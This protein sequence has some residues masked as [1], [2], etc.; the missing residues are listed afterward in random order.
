MRGMA[1]AA[2]A[3]AAAVSL[4]PPP[5]LP[6]PPGICVQQLP[7]LLRPVA[8]RANDPSAGA[9]EAAQA[10]GRQAAG[11]RQLAGAGSS[12]PR[13]E[14][15]ATPLAAVLAQ[16][17]EQASPKALPPKAPRRGPIKRRRTA[18]MPEDAI[19]K[20][21]PQLWQWLQKI[22]VAWSTK[23]LAWWTE[24]ALE[25]CTPLLG[26][27]A[28]GSAFAAPWILALLDLLLG[29]P[30]LHARAWQDWVQAS[31]ALEARGMTWPN[32]ELLCA[33]TAL[34]VSCTTFFYRCFF[35][36][37]GHWQRFFDF[38]YVG[39]SVAGTVRSSLRSERPSVVPALQDLPVVPVLALACAVATLGPRPSVVSLPYA[40]LFLALLGSFVLHCG[41]PRLRKPWRFAL[42]ALTSSHL[43]AL[44]MLSILQGDAAQICIDIF[45]L[46]GKEVSTPPAPWATPP[47]AADGT[48]TAIHI[49]ALLALHFVL[50]NV[51]TPKD[52]E[53]GPQ[54]EVDRETQ[55]SGQELPRE[56]EQQELHEDTGAGLEALSSP[57]SDSASPTAAA[58]KD[59]A[60][61]AD[62]PDVNEVHRSRQW[63]ALALSGL[64]SLALF[65]F[66][67]R[68]P[69]LLSLPL[70]LHVFS[71]SFL[72]QLLPGVCQGLLR[73][74]CNRRSQQDA[75]GGTE[76]CGRR[77]SRYFFV[78]VTAIF[79]LNY[80]FNIYL[81]GPWASDWPTRNA[82]KL[83]RVG[84]DDYQSGGDGGSNAA[85]W[86]FFGQAVLLAIL[87]ILHVVLA[88]TI[89]GPVPLGGLPRTDAVARAM[90]RMCAMVRAANQPELSMVAV[91]VFIIAALSCEAGNSS[92][93]VITYVAVLALLVTR[94]PDSCAEL[95][96][97]LWLA[98]Q[99]LSQAASVLMMLLYI[100]D[101]LTDG[102]T[103][104][105]SLDHVFTMRSCGT[106]HGLITPHIGIFLCAW[107]Q[108]YCYCQEA[109]FLASNAS[110]APGRFERDLLGILGLQPSRERVAFTRRLIR[111]LDEAMFLVVM[112]MSVITALMPRTDIQSLF[113]L[114]IVGP[115]LL[116]YNFERVPL[117]C[118]LQHSHEQ[119]QL[120]ALTVLQYLAAFC[121]LVRIT[122]ASPL[123]PL[124]DD[125]GWVLKV[126]EVGISRPL[127]DTTAKS[128]LLG[129]TAIL[130][131]L[132]A[133]RMDAVVAAVPFR[134]PDAEPSAAREAPES[135]GQGGPPAAEPPEAPRCQAA[136]D[137]ARLRTEEAA[138]AK[139]PAAGLRS[140]S[141]DSEQT[142]TVSCAQAG[143]SARTASWE[144]RL[145]D[146]WAPSWLPVR[147]H[148]YWSAMLLIVCFALSSTEMNVLNVLMIFAVVMLCGSSKHWVQAGD[149]F[150]VATVGIMLL[151]YIFRFQVWR[152][153]MKQAW[154]EHVG[155]R[156]SR[157]EVVKHYV[158]LILCLIQKQLSYR[159]RNCND[160]R[161]P[162][163]PPWL[164]KHA[165]ILGIILLLAVAVARRH[166][167]SVL[168]ALA[169]LPWLSGR[170]HLCTKK[171]DNSSAPIPGKTTTKWLRFFRCVLVLMLLFQISVRLGMAFKVGDDFNPFFVCVCGLWS[172]QAESDCIDEWHEWTQI[173]TT[174][175]GQL[176]W[177]FL[178]LFVLGYIQQ[179][180]ANPEKRT[181]PTPSLR[182][183]LVAMHWWPCLVWTSCFLLSLEGGNCIGICFLCML[184][185][186]TLNAEN[187]LA[188]RRK[189]AWRTRFCAWGFLIFGIAAQSPLFPCSRASCTGNVHRVWMKYGD[190]VRVESYNMSLVAREYE[191]ARCLSGGEALGHD[192]WA[193]LALQTLGITRVSAEAEGFTSGLGVLLSSQL[194]GLLLAIFTTTVQLRIYG[195]D[196][197]RTELEERFINEPE[198]CRLLRATRFVHEFHCRGR[199]E[200]QAQQ[201]RHRA[202]RAQLKRIMK[203]VTAILMG[204]EESLEG[205]GSKH[206]RDGN[207][208]RVDHHR[209]YQERHLLAVEEVRLSNG[210]SE[211]LAEKVVSLFHDDITS[212]QQYLH[213]LEEVA[214]GRIQPGGELL[215]AQVRRLVV[216][217][218]KKRQ[219]PPTITEGKV[220]S[221]VFSRG[222]S[223]LEAASVKA[224]TTLQTRLGLVIALRWQWL[225]WWQVFKCSVD[226][227]NYM[228]DYAFLGV[229]EESFSLR[230]VE[231]VAQEDL[232]KHRMRNG[233]LR[234]AWKLFISNSMAMVA[235]AAV[236]AFIESRSVLDLLRVLLVFFRGLR[237]Y[238]I[239]WRPFWSLLLCYS[240]ILL[241]L[242]ALYNMPF[243]CS[244]FSLRWPIPT[245][246]P[247]YRG[248]EPPGVLAWCPVP[249]TSGIDIILGI[250]KRTGP[251]AI[252]STSWFWVVWADHFCLWAILIHRWMLIRSGVWDH[253]A[254]DPPT[255]HLKLK[256]TVNLPRGS[257]P[258]LTD[259]PDPDASRMERGVPAGAPISSFDEGTHQ[260]TVRTYAEHRDKFIQDFNTWMS[261]I[262]PASK[263]EDAENPAA[264]PADG[265][266]SPQKMGDRLKSILA[267][268]FTRFQQM[269]GN[270]DSGEGQEGPPETEEELECWAMELG[271]ARNIQRWW[272]QEMKRR[273]KI[274]CSMGHRLMK[275]QADC[276]A[277]RAG[278]GGVPSRGQE[279]V[280]EDICERCYKVITG[281]QD[282]VWWTCAAC[283]Y[284]ACDD[285][286]QPLLKQGLSMGKQA[287]T[288]V[289]KF[290]K[291]GL[292]LYWL[293]F[294]FGLF[295]LGYAVFTSKTLMNEER[296]FSESVQASS[297]G[298][299]TLFMIVVHLFVLIYDRIWH[300]FYYR[301]SG[302]STLI[303]AINLTV[304]FVML[305]GVH[306]F[307]IRSLGNTAN[308]ADAKLPVHSSVLLCGY[309]TI[310]MVYL[311]VCMVQHKHGLPAVDIDV[312]RPVASPQAQ[313][314]YMEKLRTI[315]FL[316]HYNLPFVDDLRVIIDWT[317]VRT[318]LDLFMYF[319]VEDAHSWL[320]RARHTMHVRQ[321]SFFA[322]ERAWTEKL[323]SGWFVICALLFVVLMPIIV[324]SPITP[325]PNSVPIDAATTVLRL[326]VVSAC[327]ESF[328]GSSCQVMEVDLYRAPASQIW[329]WRLNHSAVDRYYL[330]N[331]PAGVD[332]D[333]QDLV[334]PL[335]SQGTFALSPPV[336]SAVAEMLTSAQPGSP[337]VMVIFKMALNLLQGEAAPATVD[338]EACSCF[339]EADCRLDADLW[340][341]GVP[342]CHALRSEE[343]FQKTH[344]WWTNLT[345]GAPQSGS[346]QPLLLEN[347]WAPAVRLK[348]GVNPEIVSRAT[349]PDRTER[350]PLSRSVSFALVDNGNCSNLSL[351][352]DAAAPAAPLGDCGATERW[353]NLAVDGREP[354]RVTVE[355]EKGAQLSVEQNSSYGSVMGLYIGLVFVVGK[356]LRATFQDSSK[357]TIYEEIPDVGTFLDLVTAVKLAREHGDLRTEFQL[358]YELM[359]VLRSTDL[360]LTAGGWQVSGYGVCRVD[361]CPPECAE[362]Q[363]RGMHRR[364]RQSMSPHGGAAILDAPR[365]RAYTAS[366]IPL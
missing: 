230:E 314:Y 301:T 86:A 25:I 87:A 225:E 305:I 338:F 296:S 293:K 91:L 38:I 244:D 208:L 55:G 210:V 169:A 177:E 154:I 119:Y 241:V 353:G 231:S 324:F 50:T 153:L 63:G 101:G 103:A 108:H 5:P 19:R 82:V 289:K 94:G 256:T 344:E 110:R 258:L 325:F 184:L 12:P 118:A 297:F 197:Y 202:L 74:C 339:P 30:L 235:V 27:V 24:F 158:M 66:A 228:S 267:T 36:Q 139:T 352:G 343:L 18:M 92:P 292:H 329:E 80:V 321:Q 78:Y 302:G 236:L 312:L 362:P 148:N 44:L 121:L 40:L 333:L 254:I 326:L 175:N 281:T 199:L 145:L 1:S 206:C 155:L 238:P 132:A 56:V 248:W 43:S 165:D 284:H 257:Y 272:R 96:K 75:G 201:E 127:N 59:G 322:E 147:A 330:L 316:V 111:I 357:R 277:Y 220:A 37:Q 245:E 304:H 109:Q 67:V 351:D 327:T 350:E 35:S 85:P 207:L 70:F 227:A 229:D 21:A 233:P 73:L 285:C 76:Q 114:T 99:C 6:L 141:F 196:T 131:R 173:S 359:K 204:Q 223:T 218:Q 84:L 182:L 135:A 133:H 178:A 125:A 332:V 311:S 364:D 137:E 273:D 195:S 216:S 251:A 14:A 205:D 26:I 319:K 88:T 222:R 98:L 107:Q 192:T 123:V 283:E 58:A 174:L 232:H 252:D 22:G 260:D 47:G 211:V 255:K 163:C 315:Y 28:V 286:V 52:K 214:V 150:A 13:P 143:T 11:P 170:H 172:Q 53:E 261:E 8:A 185:G 246:N 247:L 151:Q 57:L 41:L 129:A 328:V 288:A 219:K 280:F 242:R 181:Q 112:Q 307:V 183:K 136:L 176:M 306:V 221:R 160:L 60:D 213:I 29:I 212:C 32:V 10:A 180:L 34:L 7:G 140:P 341:P 65:V 186:T 162:T 4:R 81:H 203:K 142:S 149:V 188:V 200:N 310:W 166:A 157:S 300:K 209:S 159:G 355:L 156:W 2:D 309:Y 117:G 263:K 54:R 161:E 115:S 89:E 287:R 299:W 250:A 126:E 331:P 134:G 259:G 64:F 237:Q 361:P 146:R 240:T 164:A 239:P 336:A 217:L 268:P 366:T 340:P 51:P 83:M 187:I 224:R 349:R 79:L 71:W 290:I 295:L 42:L 100:A 95:Q 69:S 334:W 356:Y 49:M 198:E 124:P 365:P 303:D 274:C 113:L 90:E 179:L 48:W 105:S 269:M 77:S 9:V 323:S 17:L 279:K 72:T 68:F 346:L 20:P 31:C 360:L 138:Q 23:D 313:G 276:R 354:L 46:V 130:A 128:A 45:G 358:Y 271:K 318:S 348:R 249:T 337:P 104:G 265:E 363:L 262:Q 144:E 194:G 3:A 317:V 320:F 97:N 39:F 62:P 191:I 234:I 270:V 345:Y 294:G 291:P 122:M 253:V 226:F 15:V 266:E 275:C 243:F 120:R 342:L 116:C 190:C 16:C 93:L 264:G 168:L 106:F 215:E 278:N 61:N 102:I 189:W 347:L 335:H 171:G 167:W 33:T 308:P 298:I 193:T 152:G 282:A